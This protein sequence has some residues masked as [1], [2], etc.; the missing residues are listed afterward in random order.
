MII[1]SFLF[2]DEF[3]LLAARVKYLSPVVDYFVAV[4]SSY[5][6]SGNQKKLKL[7]DYIAKYLPD[8]SSRIILLLINH[9]F[10]HPPLHMTKILNP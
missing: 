4:E 3:D 6:F 9:I 8:H 10:F 5:S 1:D 2:F 7:A